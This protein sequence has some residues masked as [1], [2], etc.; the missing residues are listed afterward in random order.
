MRAA[1]ILS[2]LLCSMAAAAGGTASRAAEA[3]CLSSADLTEMVTKHQV[4]SPGQ[5]IALARRAVP[6]ADVLRASLCRDPEALA[7][8]IMVLRKDGRLVRVTVDARSGKMKA[9]R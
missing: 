5:A 8:R 6:N 9:V 4:V 2:G 1:W 7:Y 3:A